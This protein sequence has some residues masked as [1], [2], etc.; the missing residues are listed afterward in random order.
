ME[1]KDAK[2]IGKQAADNVCKWYISPKVNSS[3]DK[4]IKERAYPGSQIEFCDS[5]DKQIVQVEYV[6]CVRL[7]DIRIPPPWSKNRTENIRKW[8][9]PDSLR[10]LKI[11]T[12]DNGEEIL[13]TRNLPEIAR[14]VDLKE[15]IPGKFEIENGIHRINVAKELGIDCMLCRVI[16]SVTLTKDQ[17]SEYLLNQDENARGSPE[18]R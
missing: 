16:E 5:E 6:R 2:A 11:R 10:T 4:F 3:L 9:T 13:D 18:G 17:A 8:A 12:N 1:S 7:E 14:E 15:K